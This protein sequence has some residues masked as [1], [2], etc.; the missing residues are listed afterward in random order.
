[1]Q[2]HQT[3]TKKSLETLPEDTC[4]ECGANFHSQI[5]VSVD[6]LD[7]SVKPISWVTLPTD[8]TNTGLVASYAVRTRAI[9]YS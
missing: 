8:Q 5:E 1:M 4:A 3:T 6:V 7:R 9:K 2:Q